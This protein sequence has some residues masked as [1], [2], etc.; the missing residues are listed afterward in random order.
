MFP[1]LDAALWAVGR[2]CLS[3][4][5][6]RK[7]GWMGSVDTN[8]SVFKTLQELA[9]LGLLPKLRVEESGVPL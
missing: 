5:K 4:T 8:E 9:I 3:E 7:M 6:G 2:L 1:F